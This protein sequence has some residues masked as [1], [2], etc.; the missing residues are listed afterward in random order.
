MAKTSADLPR[1]ECVRAAFTACMRINDV[2]KTALA[3]QG[4]NLTTP[5]VEN[6]RSQVDH[7]IVQLEKLI[8]GCRADFAKDMLTEAKRA[9]VAIPTPEE[10]KGRDEVTGRP[11]PRKFMTQAQLSSRMV[12]VVG[13]MIRA[14]SV[15]GR[16]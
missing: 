1:A 11:D 16:A 6:M 2:K 15:L 10:L 5:P 12:Q 3:F 14:E 9:V 8:S 13:A 7:L 4:M